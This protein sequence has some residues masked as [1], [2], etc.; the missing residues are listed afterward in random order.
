MADQ[1][2]PA[3]PGVVAVEL[4]LQFWQR[5]SASLPQKA[6]YQKVRDPPA[7]QSRSFVECL[8]PDSFPPL[9]NY[10]GSNNGHAEPA[11]RTENTQ[12]RN[13]YDEGKSVPLGCVHTVG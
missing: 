9:A 13:T 10:P 12:G 5:F 11:T 8:N 7:V 3:L 6:G 4:M 1:F 2:I